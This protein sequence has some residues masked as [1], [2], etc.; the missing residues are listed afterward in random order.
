MWFVPS[1]VYLCPTRRTLLTRQGSEAGSDRG[2]N[3]RARSAAPRQ[4]ARGNLGR[5]DTHQR[6]GVQRS[7]AASWNLPSSAGERYGRDCLCSS[8]RSCHGTTCH[9]H[10]ALSVIVFY[11]HELHPDSWVYW[12]MMQVAMMAGFL[13][14]YPINWW[15]VSV[16]RKERCSRAARPCQATDATGYFYSSKTALIRST[17]NARQ[18][19]RDPPRARRHP[20]TAAWWPFLSA[21]AAVVSV[22]SG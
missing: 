20:S 3:N 1:I 13:T 12:F 4:R 8:S 14:A 18:G 10:R 11:A 6:A 2:D 17:P 5:S 22:A 21:A 19:N 15:L 7:G 9:G 16:G